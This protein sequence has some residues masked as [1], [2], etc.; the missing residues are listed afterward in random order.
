MTVSVSGRQKR[1]RYIDGRTFRKTGSGVSF[2]DVSV[3]AHS[4]EDA[5]T[6]VKNTRGIKKL[7]FSGKEKKDV[8]TLAGG[9][10]L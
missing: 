6:S 7:C 1:D 5:L 2:G 8:Y 4:I 10:M 3:T 9:A